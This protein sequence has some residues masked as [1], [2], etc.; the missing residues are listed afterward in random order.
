[1]VIIRWW[2]SGC[3]FDESLCRPCSPSSQLRP[4]NHRIQL[5]VILPFE[6][7]LQEPFRG[8]RI[9]IKTER[10]TRKDNLLYS[11]ESL[12][13][14]GA[15]D[16]LSTANYSFTPLCTHSIKTYITEIPHSCNEPK[17]MQLQKAMQDSPPQES[18][19][20]NYAGDPVQ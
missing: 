2:L 5:N 13:A 18:T 7:D 17:S 10:V 14:T 4:H 20:G 15:C 8:N 9:C 6:S 16:L 12:L 3:I 19:S 11:R 1:M